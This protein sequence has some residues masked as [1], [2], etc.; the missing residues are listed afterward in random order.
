MHSIIT[1][2]LI[3]QKL[4]RKK[5]G[6]DLLGKSLFDDIHK[7]NIPSRKIRICLVNPYRLLD[8]SKI[9]CSLKKTT[10]IFLK[11][12]SMVDSDK[13]MNKNTNIEINWTKNKFIFL[14]KAFLKIKINY[15]YLNLKQYAKFYYNSNWPT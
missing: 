8:R 6:G 3:L 14:K 13:W 12:V 2:N 15:N 7:Q 5:A 1:W 9:R 11:S 10:D 4:H